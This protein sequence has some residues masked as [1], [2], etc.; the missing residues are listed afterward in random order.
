[1]GYALAPAASRTRLW[2]VPS[3]GKPSKTAKS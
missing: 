2:I 3:L 1:M